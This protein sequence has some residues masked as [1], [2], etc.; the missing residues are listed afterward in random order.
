M[1][2]DERHVRTGFGEPGGIRH[3]RREHLQVEAESILGEPRDI[4]PDFW[5]GAEVRPGRKAVERVFVPVQLHA[6]AAHQRI[7]RQTIQLRTDVV[8]VEICIGDDGVRPAMILRGLLHPGGF[9]LEAVV[10][11]VGLHIDRARYAG[12]REVAEIFL[13]RIVAPDRLVGAEDARPH[14]TAQPGQVGLT[15]D[16]MMGI[17]E[18][19]HAAFL[20]PSESTCET[21]AA[22]DPPSTR[23]STKRRM[24]ISASVCG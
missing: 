23:S 18:F 8:D 2:Q 11:P 21:I 22:V 3:L 20:C 12:A 5:I 14:R 10:G 7:A 9:V 24:A 4:A 19:G 1:L 16:M 13:N 17:D 6:H 15:P